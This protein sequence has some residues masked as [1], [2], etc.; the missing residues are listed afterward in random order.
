MIKKRSID[1]EY[2]EEDFEINPQRDLPTSMGRDLK[3]RIVRKMYGTAQEFKRLI[4]KM[5]HIHD[6]KNSIEVEDWDEKSVFTKAVHYI[7]L[8]PFTLVRSATIMPPDE[9]SWDR[10]R[11]TLFPVFASLFIMFAFDCMLRFNMIFSV[12]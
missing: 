5:Y 12:F 11:A 4:K 6:Y 8:V 10:A 3:R 9:E 7:I 1:Y 2:C